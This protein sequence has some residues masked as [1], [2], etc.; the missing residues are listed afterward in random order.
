MTLLVCSAGLIQVSAKPTGGVVSQG[1]ASFNSS[2]PQLTINQTSGNT[3]INWQTFNIGSGETVTFNQPSSTSVAWNFINDPNA[4][5][6]NGNLN[7]N[8][9]VVLQNPN[10]F[11]VGGSA[12]ITAHGLVMTT[13]STP[14]LNLSGGGTWSFDAPPPMAKI[15]NYGKISITGGG[16][17]YLI[18]SDIINDG[19]ISAPNGNIGL[20]AGQKVLLSMSPDG[21][22]LSAEVTLPQGSVDN[23]GNLIA[24][25]GS[26]AAQAQFV[27]QNGLVQANS[28]Q[29]INGTI[30]LVASDSIKLG[31]GSIISARGD[32]QGN[33]AGGSI[34][35]KADNNFSDQKGS[36]IN[37]SGGAQ[38]G[39][40]GSVEISASSMAAVNSQVIGQAESGCVGGK[41]L[42]DPDFIE[43]DESGGDSL[44][45]D[46]NNGSV[47][48]GNSPGG[49]LFLDVGTSDFG[50]SDSAFIG[51]S[52]ITLQAKYDITLDAGTVWNLSGSTGQ[53]SGQLN[54][55]AGRNI[56]FGDGSKISD[57]NNWSV[58]LQ[59][60][61]DFVNNVVQSG[62][63]SIYLGNFDGSN[64]LNNSGSI[65]T[66][67]GSIS[68]TA[69]Q[70][71]L[72]GSGG[73]T[74][75]KGGDISV[76]ALNGNVNS[77]TSASGFNYLP[78]AP[79][80]TPFSVSGLGTTLRINFNQSNL[81]GI[82]TAG[83]GN[84][85]INAG[86]D[87]ISFPTATVAAGDPGIGAF[88]SQ[89][90]NVTITAGGSVYGNYIVMN[91]A[92]IINAGQNIGT[93][94]GNQNVALSL[95][96]GSWDL[97]AQGDIY[98]Q[99]VRNPNGVF[100][101]TASGGSG[102]GD[103]LFD[104]DPSASVSLTAGDGVHITG[105]GLPRPEGGV[106]LILPPTLII[107]A[108]SGG[109][110]LQTPTAI[111]SSGNSVFLSD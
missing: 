100:N 95:A 50:F 43:L 48:V 74:T 111:D 76:T 107:N 49:T 4:S 60:G 24:D 108:G 32:A 109:V 63:G 28:V 9:Y 87:V 89:S 90:G 34:T 18:A 70:D 72:L 58:S 35:I 68:L 2:G 3:F 104:Y 12:V 56:I 75:I 33:S 27:N 10:G 85:N 19:T 91:G 103:H 86:G 88:G 102:P 69:G 80:Y 1:A 15:V 5:S 51:L 23:E 73:V 61:Y 37:V 11:T 41:L 55:E 65:Q 98:L 47:S 59:A 46:G 20:Y 94:E 42:L 64:P 17:A 106:P 26:I 71:V 13:A 96:K 97:N 14:A 53:S 93:S 6:I 67:L 54:L 45:V 22:G 62:I 25:A 84:V 29:D 21:R 36:T 78:I 39:D 57:A 38:G 99:E 52:Q 81:G 110:T 66:A 31:A 101:G 40:G 7:A 79:Y 105:S 8:G 16:Q 30:E 77:G 44:N 92:G 82:A 83:G